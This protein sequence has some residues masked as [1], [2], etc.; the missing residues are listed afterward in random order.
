MRLGVVVLAVAAA[1]TACTEREVLEPP[2][3]YK[4]AQIISA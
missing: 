2:L 4:E 1:A 3:P